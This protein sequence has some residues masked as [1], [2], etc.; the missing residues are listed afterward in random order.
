MQY[1]IDHIA[2]IVVGAVILLSVIAMAATSNRGAIEAAQ[3]DMGKTELRSLVDALEQDLSNMG[4]GMANPNFNG[5]ATNRVVQ[6]YTEAA[7]KTT[8]SF[9]GLRDDDMS[10]PDPSLV[11]Y[12]WEQSGTV[13][14]PDGTS[15]P[16]WVVTRQEGTTPVTTFGTATDFSVTLLKDSPV[17]GIKPV[18]PNSHPDS[19]ALVRYVDVAVGLAAPAESEGLV[20]RAQWTKRFRPINLDNDRRRI[21]AAKPPG[22]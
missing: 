22:S 1:M 12:E 9:F 5:A 13:T 2:A 16:A 4:S 20:Q 14:F 8:L 21:V 11:T 19:L 18:S 7:G 6:T 15:T 10:T 17:L 3:V